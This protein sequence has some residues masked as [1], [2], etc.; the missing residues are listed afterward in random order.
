MRR[1][2]ELFRML[3]RMLYEFLFMIL[4]VLFAELILLK[5]DINSI[6]IF[7]VIAAFFVSY[8]LR[9]I[10]DMPVIALAFHAVIGMFIFKV[11]IQTSSKVLLLMVLVYLFCSSVIYIRV[12]KKL[13]ALDEIPWVPFFLAVLMYLMGI[14]AKS[15]VFI[16]YIYVIILLMVGVCSMLTYLEGLKKYIDSTKDVQGLPLNKVISRN[17]A[18]VIIIT[19]LIMMCMVIG[20][21]IDYSELINVIKNVGKSLIK[22]ISSVFMILSIV[23][24]RMINSESG[25]GFS[26]TQEE[27][28][29]IKSYGRNVGSSF[30]V[31][32]YVALCLIVLIVL[33]RL[34][35]VLIA[36]VFERNKSNNDIVE[37][38]EQKVEL[39][40][41]KTKTRKIFTPKSY[42]ERFRKKYKNSVERYKHFVKLTKEKTC[43][44]I[45]M[46]FEKEELGNISDMTNL[47]ASIRYGQT[48]V[49]KGLLRESKDI[50]RY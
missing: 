33:T 25:A 8:V 14:Y 40:V 30:M 50:F 3:A 6:H 36:F 5:H 42:E 9:N 12:G 19:L 16:N 29:A 20:Y 47:Y 18:M 39:K 27:S 34:L 10:T 43:R 41:E 7:L 22:L 15:T 44:D 1:R 48:K 13:K 4:L 32:I 38:A 37:I 26:V 21:L 24:S 23:F 46:D 45:E 49:D 2:I 17:N 35:R 11:D 28:E 31:I